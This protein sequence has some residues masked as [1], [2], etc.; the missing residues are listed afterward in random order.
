M[1]SRYQPEV[2]GLRAVAVLA[3]M[4]FHAAPAAFRGGFV[5]VDVFFVISG[6]LI[7]GIVA[8]G[9]AAGTFTVAGF[10]ERRARRILPA[11]GVVLAAVAVASVAVLLPRDLAAMGKS[12]A[13]VATMTANLVFLG[14]A[15]YFGGASDIKPL[16][17]T[18]SLAVEEQFYLGYPLLL[19]A[20]HRVAPAWTGRCL[21]ALAIASLG[22]CAWVASAWPNATYYLA[23][24]RA[25]ELL[26]GGLL[27]VS[28]PPPVRAPLAREALG[29]AG[30]AAIGAS[31][32]LVTPATPFPVPGAVP[33]CLGAAALIHAAGSGPSRV[34]GLLASRPAVAIGLGSYSLYLWHWPLLALVR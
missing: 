29:V 7:S 30:L 11:L 33:A 27:A 13:G 34:G 23:P 10:Y 15:A 17:H 14:E 5:G 19:L 26:L 2:D 18:W 24:F 31:V 21:A 20:V 28:P 25:W 12:L 3:V 22:A 9:L 16:L 6:Y 8:G 32:M 1:S 4:A